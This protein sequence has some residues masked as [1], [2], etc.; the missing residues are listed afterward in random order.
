[1]SRFLVGLL[2][3]LGLLGCTADAASPPRPASPAASAMLGPPL[4]HSVSATFVSTAAQT[5]SGQEQP[6]E[7]VC[8]YFQHG[9]GTRSWAITGKA[10]LATDWNECLDR[11][12]S[13]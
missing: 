11:F 1:M 7:T 4:S 5:H 13:W 12:N 2:V 8:I 9:D 10:D 3:L 6:T